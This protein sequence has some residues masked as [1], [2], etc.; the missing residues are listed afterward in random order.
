MVRPQSKPIAIDKHDVVLQSQRTGTLGKPGC[1]GDCNQ[2]EMVP[3][4][5]VSCSQQVTDRFFTGESITLGC[6]LRLN[7]GHGVFSAAVP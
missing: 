3:S 6:V 5:A 7:Q 2:L 1:I 4:I